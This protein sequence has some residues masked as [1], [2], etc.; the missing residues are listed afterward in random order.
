M[1]LIAVSFSSTTSTSAVFVP[2]ETVYVPAWNVVADERIV[3][4]PSLTVTSTAVGTFP[5]FTVTAVP[6]TP[7]TVI[8][9]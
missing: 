4:T 9:L 5:L 6:D 1:K 3:A 8:S 7:S 2:S